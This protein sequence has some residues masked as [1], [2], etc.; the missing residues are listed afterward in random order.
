MAR[1][2]G[3]RVECLTTRS[4]RHRVR[5]RS[6][7]IDQSSTWMIAGKLCALLVHRVQRDVLLRGRRFRRRLRRPSKR[8]RVECLPRMDSNHE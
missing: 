6:F 7:N 5:E 4:E 2:T 1:A 8:Q 3:C